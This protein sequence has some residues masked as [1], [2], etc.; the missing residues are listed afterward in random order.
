MMWAI[1]TRRKFV[2]FAYNRINA[3][4]GRIT[5]AV[6]VENLPRTT[7][8][9]AMFLGV[10]GECVYERCKEIENNNN[11]KNKNNEKVNQKLQRI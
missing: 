4:N 11:I 1:L 6:M 10:V 8:E 9:S 3:N 2:C 7:E 5:G